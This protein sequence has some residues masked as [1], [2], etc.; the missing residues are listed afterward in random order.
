[1]KH[2]HRCFGL[3]GILCVVW[4]SSLAPQA[5]EL[6][7][8]SPLPEMPVAL[9]G[10]F[11]GTSGDVLLV[12][13]GTSEA[14]VRM[15]SSPE[16]WSRAVYTL[17]SGEKLWKS[18]LKLERPVAF[19]GSV[20]VLDNPE[21]PD[22]E[23][24]VICVGGMDTTRTYADV[25]RLQ[26]IDGR[27][28]QTSMPPLPAPRACAGVALLDNTIYVVCGREAEY[29]ALNSPKSDLWALDLSHEAPA[30]QVLEPFPGAPRVGP[31]ATARDGALYVAGGYN[32]RRQPSGF[33]DAYR[34]RPGEGWQRIADL[35]RSVAF[36]PVSPYGQSHIFVFGGI[37]GNKATTPLASLHGNAD[38]S[39][40]ILAY[41][42]I[43]DTWVEMGA[44]PG[45][46]AGNPV[47]TW[48]DR[49]GA[50][51]LVSLG[52]EDSVG[53]LLANVS[54]YRAQPLQS[55]FQVLDYVALLAYLSSLVAMG[56]YFSRRRKGTDDFFLA[57]RRIPWW[58]AG[59]SI[60]G[61]QLSSITFMA[62]PAKVYATDWV[63]FLSVS[64][65]VL[66]APV[67]IRCYLPF[68]RRLNVTSAYEYLEVRFNLAVRLF[69]SASFVL[70]QLG[71][72]A[73]VLLLPSIA[74][75]AVTGIDVR[76]CIV[77]MG[78]MATFYT[79]IGGIEAVIWTDVL[80]VFVLVGGGI[81]S[82]LTIA[83]S[84]DGGLFGIVSTG[85]AEGKFHA[86]NLNWDIATAS[87]WVVLVGNLFIN[88]A[89]YTSDQAVIQ[90]YLTT[91]SEKL[92]AKSI[93]TNAALIIP[94]S[95]IWYFLGTCLY[96]FYKIHPDQL[97]PSL[98]TDA[99]FPLFIAQELPMGLSGLVIAG[100]FA[101]TM[102]TLDSSLNSVAA[103]IVTDFYR[104]FRPSAEDGFCLKIAS[105]LTILLGVFATMASIVMAGPD[106]KSLWD[107]F[108][109]FV[110]LLLGG[111]AGLFVLGIFTRRAHGYGALV[112][113]A[114]SSFALYQ[115]QKYQ[116][117]HVFLYAAIGIL[118]CVIV[119]YIASLLL[120]SKP[121]SL[122]G[123]T[124]YTLEKRDS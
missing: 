53:S 63:Y 32:T 44:V 17:V 57:G 82:V 50:E 89:P 70:F 2:S 40:A 38:L 43:T 78:V 76:V 95:L 19:G 119:G 31:V 3:I 74:L 113:A 73:I 122:D 23:S 15:N 27:V 30:W 22:N 47:V 79:V 16:K 117:T 11:A 68:F 41:H 93:W 83:F 106:I 112:G 28:T 58:A 103:V 51:I 20:T 48:E 94:V 118:T 39:S 65:I 97:A 12:A 56:L 29:P 92:A 110:G 84:V 69:G 111:L 72:M 4:S 114:A 91:K 90:R 59:I 120:P 37:D 36:A 100:L 98:P 121:R 46:L 81:L 77:V 108:N 87:I 8:T 42:T 107:T 1:M 62:I 88:L 55:H 64:G 45:T 67:V 123:L 25:F 85:L 33:V 71:R 35:P 61:T 26:W 49:T 54:A 75:T 10:V 102:S 115:V 105:G 6:F 60:F 52:G 104:R 99:V 5:R 34:Y 86:V 24:G 66:V 80:Q 13:G 101:A 124:L 18:D 96:V 9:T 109:A 116:A 14:F 7:Q 21:T